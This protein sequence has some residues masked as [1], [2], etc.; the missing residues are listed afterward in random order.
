M[1]AGTECSEC[2]D[3]FKSY[4][5]LS[6]FSVADLINNQNRGKLIYPSPYILNL[7]LTMEKIF[8]ENIDET[9]SIFDTLLEK[10]IND[11]KLFAFPSKTHRTPMLASCIHYY[12]MTRMK[13]FVR[14]ANR[15]GVSLSA[16]LRKQAKVSDKK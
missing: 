1:Q 16:V 13:K 8:E 4:E 9:E 10:I 6:I 7:F 14:L 2:K 3:A 5:E 15:K 12:I 11:R